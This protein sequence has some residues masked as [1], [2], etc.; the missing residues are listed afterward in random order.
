MGTYRV[1]RQGNKVLCNCRRLQETEPGY[2]KPIPGATRGQ[3]ASPPWRNRGPGR[4]WLFPVLASE[5]VKRSPMSRSRGRR[6]EAH[7][8]S[9]ALTGPGFLP[10]KVGVAMGREDPSW[11]KGP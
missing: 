3:Q 2:T 7:P 9:Q 5:A 4:D 8:T 6:S 1:S 10:C 11:A